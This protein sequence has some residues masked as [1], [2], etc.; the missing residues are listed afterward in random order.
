MNKI[1]LSDNLYSSLKI[2]IFVIISM[3][4]NY[5]LNPLNKKKNPFQF[6]IEILRF[7]Y[8]QCS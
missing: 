3:L 4:I 6:Q 8:C 7:L 1:Q 2:D 5:S